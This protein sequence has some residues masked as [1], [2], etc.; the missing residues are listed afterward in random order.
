M[1]FSEIYRN[2]MRVNSTIDLPDREKLSREFFEELN[3]Y[4]YPKYVNWAHE[5]FEGIHVRERG[6]DV[7]LLWVDI[8]IGIE[9]TF[10][11]KEVAKKGNQILN[12]LRYNHID[13]GNNIYLITPSIPEVWFLFFAGIKGGMVTIPTATNMT[14]WELEYRFKT[15]P[16]HVVV[17][18][19]SNSSVIDKTLMS[20]NIKPKAKIIIGEKKGWFK[21]DKI[22]EMSGKAVPAKT[23]PDD[24]IFCFF[25]SATAGMPKR[26]AHSAISYPV[27]HMSTAN[28]I[29]LNTGDIHNNL[30]APGWGKWAW[31]SLFVPFIVGATTTSFYTSKKFNP[32][33]Y[34]K[35]LVKY[36]VNTFCAPP[37]AYRQFVLLDLKKFNFSFLRESIGAGEPLNPEVIRK[38]KKSTNTTIR[39]IYGQTES[40]AMIGNPPWFKDKVIAG[41][42]GKP[43]YMYDII[44]A[45]DEGKEIDN[46]NVEGN[47]AVRLSKWRAVGLFYEYIKDQ[48]NMK[49]AFKHN[50]Y[51]TGDRAYFDE[52]GYWWFVGRGD[53]IIKSS[54]YR[55]GPFEVESALAEHEAVVESAIVGSPDSKRWQIVKAF[56][57]LKSDFAGSKEIAQSIFKKTLEILPKYEIPRII[58]FVDELPKTISGKIKR[59]ELKELEVEKKNKGLIG[60]NEY[61]Y[62]DVM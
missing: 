42:F 38:W 13:K 7:A 54:D 33:K 8:D 11:Y 34:L 60:K 27:G 9:K 28:L 31:S 52:N 56:V 47:I 25:T 26:V 19:E 32:E 59:K 21:F 61:F 12:F 49:E 58:E 16:P 6:D 44:L 2:F 29:G 45:D 46:K 3:C 35:A 43:H 50:L 5:I 15:S 41:S 53:D 17:A 36:N 37:T 55:I 14:Q 30:S 20:M 48:P 40:T 23:K 57:I 24:I 22:E 4:S 39:D 18:D 1:S 10:T 51:Y 62:S